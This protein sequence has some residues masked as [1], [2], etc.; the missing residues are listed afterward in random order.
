[1][2]RVWRLELEN[3]LQLIR[4][5]SGRA[6]HIQLLVQGQRNCAERYHFGWKSCKSVQ[7]YPPETRKVRFSTFM[8]AFKTGDRR[9]SLSSFVFKVEE[10]LIHVILN[11]IGAREYPSSAN[12]SSSLAHAHPMFIPSPSITPPDMAHRSHRIIQDISS[13]AKRST[14]TRFS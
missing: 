2:R 13:S 4:K 9:A 8:M 7:T 5:L 3:G 11:M 6:D 10:I 14:S 12:I 1:M